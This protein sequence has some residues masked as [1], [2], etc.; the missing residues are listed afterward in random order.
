MDGTILPNVHTAMPD[1][2]WAPANK[3]RGCHFHSIRGFAIIYI[4]LKN[5]FGENQYFIIQ[6]FYNTTVDDEVLL[7]SAGIDYHIAFA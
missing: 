4:S 2:Q 6:H 7:C 5:C 3:N 1:Y